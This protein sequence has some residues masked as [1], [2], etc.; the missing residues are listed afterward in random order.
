MDDTTRQWTRKK[1]TNERTRKCLNGRAKEC[2]VN[3]T[4]C[5]IYLHQYIFVSTKRVSSTVGWQRNR[6]QQQQQKL[7]Q[8]LAIKLYGDVCLFILL[9]R[10]L[11]IVCCRC[12][13]VRS[14][15]RA[16][17]FIIKWYAMRVA[18]QL[19]DTRQVQFG[20]HHWPYA[21]ATTAAAATTTPCQFPHQ[22]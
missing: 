21:T 10:T 16:F 20:Y 13:H 9:A 14:R 19:T 5:S 2:S 11:P 4:L 8:S 1:K 15:L 22:K 17:S 7:H 18:S 12:P 6:Q 3:C